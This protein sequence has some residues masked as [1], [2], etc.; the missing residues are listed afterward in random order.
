MITISL[1]ISKTT[2]L[3]IEFRKKGGQH[4]TICING[5]E[6]WRVKS[7]QFLG[8]AIN[9]N[10]SWTSHVDMTVK[11]AQ[12]HLFFL[13][14]FRKFSMSIRTLTNFYRC[15]TESILSGCITD[16]YGNCSVQDHKKLQKVVCTAQTITE[17]NHTPPSS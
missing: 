6:A 3:I 14:W 12:E 10:L 15:T 8:V 2:E 1:N 16:S 7:V 9:N 4:A 13:K 5:A 17:A 11:K